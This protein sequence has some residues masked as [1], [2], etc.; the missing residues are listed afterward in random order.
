MSHAPPDRTEEIRRLLGRELPGLAVHSVARAGAG[1]DHVAYE[2]NGDL[3]V[4]FATEPDRADR[5]RQ[6][7]AERRV[8]ATVRDLSP[9]TVPDP[10]V[11]VADDGAMVYRKIPGTP[12][13]ELREHLP[14]LDLARFGE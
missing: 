1:V 2:V 10:V 7:H 3:I 6:V 14:G 11:V 9:L 4:R 5:A 12:I 13:L 8:L